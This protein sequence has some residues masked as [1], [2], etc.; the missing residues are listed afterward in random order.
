MKKIAFLLFS[1]LVF[2]NLFAQQ[3]KTFTFDNLIVPDTGFWNGSDT[4]HYNHTFGDETITFSN[5]YDSTYGFWSNSAFSTW[6]DT[7]TSDYSNQWSVYAG[8][9][10]SDSVFGLFYVPLDFNNNYNTIPVDVDFNQSVVLDSL[11]ITNSTYTALTIKNGNNYTRPFSTDSSDYYKVIIYSIFQTDTLDTTEV[12]LADYTTNTPVVHN[13]WIKVD[14]DS[15]T[16]TKLAFD[17][18]TTDVGAYGANTP[19]YFCVDDFSYKIL[20]DNIKSQKFDIVK[21][22][23]NPASNFVSINS[24]ADKILIYSIDGQLIRIVED[25]SANQFIDVNDLGQGTYILKIYSNKEVK[26]GKFVKL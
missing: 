6:T 24:S 10:H 13:D 23:P 1:V 14:F 4:T 25:Y 7:V 2:S 3:L 16:V 12:M 26:I 22:Y 19:L 20:Q 5:Y 21:V 11:F 9:A 17:I 18:V 8:A 15:L